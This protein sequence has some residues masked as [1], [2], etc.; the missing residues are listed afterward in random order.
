MEIF[1]SDNEKWILTNFGA[2]GPVANDSN[3]RAVYMFTK[4]EALRVFKSRKYR[5]QLKYTVMRNGLKTPTIGH[6]QLAWVYR[7]ARSIQF[8]CQ[9]W[10][11][12]NATALRNWAL[13]R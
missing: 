8:G 6:F 10:Q 13:D 5:P 3:G 4:S 2:Y 9:L 1:N 11:G 12:K 7:K